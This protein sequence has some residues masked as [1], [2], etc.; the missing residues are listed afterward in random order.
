[1]YS[2]LRAH[3]TLG[4]ASS[5]QCGSGGLS[6]CAT[7][8]IQ[9]GNFFA[10]GFFCLIVLVLARRSPFAVSPRSAIKW[11]PSTRA[12]LKSILTFAFSAPLCARFLRR[13]LISKAQLKPCIFSVSCETRLL[14]GRVIWAGRNPRHDRLYWLHAG[15]AMGRRGIGPVPREAGCC[16]GT[17]ATGGT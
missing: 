4:K 14:S 10:A 2:G 12:K 16:S 9:A 13:Y 17:G 3:G 8:V 7:G 6:S 5:R 11:P 15:E 1:M